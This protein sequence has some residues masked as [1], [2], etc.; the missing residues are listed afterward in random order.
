MPEYRVICVGTGNILTSPRRVRASNGRAFRYPM[1]GKIHIHG[2]EATTFKAED[3]P[4]SE[5][6]SAYAGG[7]KIQGYGMVVVSDIYAR[8]LKTPVVADGIEQPREWETKI[9]TA[10]DWA[11]NLIRFW[12][13][14]FPSRRYGALIIKGEL[15]T[16]DELQRARDL[17]EKSAREHLNVVINDQSLA[18]QGHKAFKRG[19][20][21]V[22]R[23]WGFEYG[24]LLPETVDTLA[25]VAVDEGRVSCP[26]CAELILPQAKICIHCKT[27]FKMPLIDYL[28]APEVRAAS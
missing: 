25:K 3:L 11:L 20:G 15:P 2:G 4:K 8:E 26:E 24:V 18:K 7:P 14:P 19:Y 27:K 28:T 17:R 23:A 1:P 10:K 12:D 16:A 6:M 21:E 13:A 9:E 5:L 22:D